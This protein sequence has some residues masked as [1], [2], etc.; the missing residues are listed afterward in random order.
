MSENLTKKEKP[1]T[2]ASLCFSKG[3]LSPLHQDQPESFVIWL[4]QILRADPVPTESASPHQ[5]QQSGFWAAWYI[6]I[7]D[8][9]CFGASGASCPGIREKLYLES[10]YL[11]HEECSCLRIRVPVS[12]PWT[13]CWL[14]ALGGLFLASLE[15]RFLPAV[16]PVLPSK[17]IWVYFYH[18]WSVNWQRTNEALGGVS[19]IQK[20]HQSSGLS[21]ALG[22][23][24][25]ES[26]GRPARQGGYHEDLDAEGA[27]EGSWEWKQSSTK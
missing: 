22:P 12:A 25:W 17:Y 13:T 10:I 5:A 7:T 4:M 15:L 14:T 21:R 1:K 24:N 16:N 26:L 18:T 6:L 3:E 23:D 20:A 19:H 8:N 11:L 2:R 9:H 27:G